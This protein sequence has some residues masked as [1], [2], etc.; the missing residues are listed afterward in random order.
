MHLL[1][2]IIVLPQLVTGITSSLRSTKVDSV[3]AELAGYENIVNAL[4]DFSAR[5]LM[6]YQDLYESMSNEKYRVDQQ[7]TTRIQRQYQLLESIQKKQRVKVS[8]LTFMSIP[9]QPSQLFTEKFEDGWNENWTYD[10]L[11]F[12]LETTSVGN[13]LVHRS[14][15]DKNSAKEAASPFGS[16]IAE[17][18]PLD[19]VLHRIFNT[20]NVELSVKMRLDGGAAIGGLIFGYRGKGDGRA[21]SVWVTPADSSIVLVKFIPQSFGGGIRLVRKVMMPV[22]LDRIGMVE[23]LK[24]NCQ[25]TRGLIRVTYAGQ[26]VM[27]FEGG[28]ESKLDDSL[29]SRVG[30][31]ARG[32]LSFV[33]IIAKPLFN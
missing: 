12:F 29:E 21:F 20:A 13:K 25:G 18:P 19:I 6:N 3:L 28:L 9:K 31:V 5:T 23:E 11:S 8:D 22:V 14:G 10:E 30:V 16:K 32:D 1:S 27:E 24:V 4:Y 26:H 17:G 7:C 2:L 15:I 33:E